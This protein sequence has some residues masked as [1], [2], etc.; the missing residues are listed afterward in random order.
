MKV[1]YTYIDDP[2][3][4]WDHV[5]FSDWVKPWN[6]DSKIRQGLICFLV[7]RDNGLQEYL[8]HAVSMSI[9]G[10]EQ[11]NEAQV[12]PYK[13]QQAQRSLEDWL[14]R[15]FIPGHYGK[16]KKR[17][18][19]YCSRFCWEEEHDTP[20]PG[21][22]YRYVLWPFMGRW[23]AF[24]ANRKL[25]EGSAFEKDGSYWYKYRWIAVVKR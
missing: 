2:V 7:E 19:P 6:Q 21:W 5:I 14:S 18:A 8:Q 15:V 13:L 12:M 17:Y 3:H 11:S 22:F 16:G 20:H 24:Q 4:C 23:R 1:E 9:S 25:K 10:R